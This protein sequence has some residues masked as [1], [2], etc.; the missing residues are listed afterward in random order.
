[1]LDLVQNEIIV[2]VVLDK[3]NS[4][5]LLTNH[6]S[7]TKKLSSSVADSLWFPYTRPIKTESTNEAANRLLLS[8]K[9]FSHTPKILHVIRIF[10]THLLPITQ[11][12]TSRIIYLLCE[13]TDDNALSTDAT[14]NKSLHWMNYTQM[15]IAQRR[16]QLMGLEPIQ[17]L[18]R[19]EEKK[20]HNLDM[21]FFFY[22]PRMTYVEA[23]NP[24][25]STEQLVASAKFTKPIQEKLFA[26]FF[27][28]AFPSEYLSFAKFKILF[29]KILSANDMTILPTKL[30]NYFFSFDLQFRQVL[31][32]N[33]LLL[34]LA[35]LDPITQHGST[36]A[37]QRCRYIFRYYIY[38]EGLHANNEDSY[39]NQ[40]GV[41]MN[42][43]QFKILTNDINAMKKNKPLREEELEAETVNGFKQFGLLSH[44]ET[45]ALSDF[46]IGVGQLK[47]RG[48]SVLFRLNKSLKELVQDYMEVLSLPCNEKS[49]LDKFEIQNIILPKSE[50]I[51]KQHQE[52]NALVLGETAGYEL[53]TH[54]VK[55][56]RTGALFDIAKLWEIDG[57]TTP[58]ISIDK[59]ANNF[60][61]KSSIDAKSTASFTRF[62]SVDFFNQLSQPNEMLK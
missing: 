15:R 48:T 53:A 35:A 26:I 30:K 12:K 22:E 8:L 20:I 18:K 28:Y 25:T 36:P 56:K 6:S 42:F 2:C 37:E 17:L 57:A 46:L 24:S 58:N 4:S 5:I 14:E 59:G 13:S 34:G 38:D 47:F 9:F 55:V 40:A 51:T 10:S 11:D 27:S 23:V 43:D 31:T 33:E 16:H 7:R 49:R 39:I 44:K 41:N 62:T 21:N 52:S 3:S 50:A 32:F 29:E 1:M 61:F 45:L 54:T 19:I 60:D